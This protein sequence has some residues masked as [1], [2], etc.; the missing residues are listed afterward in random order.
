M[1]PLE[2]ARETLAHPLRAGTGAACGDAVSAAPRALPRAGCGA[3]RGA[4]GDGAYRNVLPHPSA[5]SP[6]AAPSPVPGPSRGL[7]ARAAEAGT[8]RDV[9]G[10]FQPRCAHISPRAPVPRGA[11]A[12]VA[13]RLSRP[14]RGVVEGGRD[15]QLW[16]RGLWPLG[17]HWPAVTGRVTRWF[18]GRERRP[19]PPLPPCAE[20]PRNAALTKPETGSTFGQLA[21]SHCPRCPA[22]QG[23]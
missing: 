11:A 3:A 17:R 21:K 22:L 5:R 15:G 12:G 8:A 6:H 4:A 2:V 7:V 1:A 18:R 20:Q 14:G 23:F 9:A 19:R 13:V 16:P 10:G